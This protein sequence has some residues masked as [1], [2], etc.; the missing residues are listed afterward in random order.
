MDSC[1]AVGRIREKGHGVVTN[2]EMRERLSTIRRCVGGDL[3]Q[4][5]TELEFGS[6][7]REAMSR[8]LIAGLKRIRHELLDRCPW[9]RLTEEEK[10]LINEFKDTRHVCIASHEA[11]FGPYI[12]DPSL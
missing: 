11:E 12:E 6:A 4:P 9:D 2:A 5:D 1:S 8:E 3:Q 10:L 7:G